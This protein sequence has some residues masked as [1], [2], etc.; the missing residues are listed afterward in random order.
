MTR[1]RLML[2]S[3]S[4]C[5]AL[6][7]TAS[8]ELEVPIGRLPPENRPL[9]SLSGS[10]PIDILV[11]VDNSGSMLDEQAQLSRAMFKEECPIQGLTAVPEALQNPDGEL[12]EDLEE[13]CGFAQILAAYERDFRVGVITTDVNACDNFAPVTQGGEEWGHRPQRGCLQPIPSTGQKVITR[14]DFD[15]AEKFIEMIGAIG[16][17]GSPF[18]R[19]LDA[20]DFFLR[21]DT[22]VE[23]CEGDLAQLRRPNADLLIVFVTD[24]DDCS[25]ADGAGG[26]DDETLEAC[27]PDD[28]LVTE[29]NPQACY[30]NSDDLLD[31]AT[32]AERFLHHAG[33]GALRVLTVGG[34][35][36]TDLEDNDAPHTAAGC[37]VNPDGAIDSGCF[38]NGGQSNFTG[39]GQPCGEDTADE[40]GGLACCS[41]DAASRYERLVNIV[42]GSVRSICA[43]EYVSAFSRALE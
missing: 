38:A 21:G 34:A 20:A 35:V 36:P 30:D 29:H 14:Q 2:P 31:V 5:I 4:I 6:I 12:L 33:E 15:I 42:D 19:G 28:S 18:E 39:P 25:H 16:N 10:G 32:Y 26:Y 27:G 37:F 13:L 24:E 11:V 22:F 17:Y 23:E 43:G 40:R 41:A 8:C 1:F 9:R 3:M 7:A